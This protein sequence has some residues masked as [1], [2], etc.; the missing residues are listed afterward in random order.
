MSFFTWTKSPPNVVKFDDSKKLKGTSNYQEWAQDVGMSFGIFLDRLV[1]EGG[2]TKPADLDEAKAENWEMWQAWGAAQINATISLQGESP[3]PRDARKPK[4]IWDALKKAFSPTSASSLIVESLKVLSLEIPPHLTTEEFDKIMRT[5]TSDTERAVTVGMTLETLK[6]SIFIN[7]LPSSFSH[8]LAVMTNNNSKLPSLS[9][10]QS[11]VRGILQVAE[12]P[13]G[14]KESALNA[15][16]VSARKAGKNKGKPPQPCACGA[17]HWYD[18]CTDPRGIKARKERDSKRAKQKKSKKE[19]AEP[20]E[21]EEEGHGAYDEEEVYIKFDTTSPSS[22]IIADTGASVHISPPSPLITSIKTIKPVRIRGLSGVSIAHKQGELAFRSKEGHDFVLKRVLILPSAAHA[23]VSTS[24]LEDDFNLTFKIAK[25]NMS[26]IDSDGTIVASASR[27]PT[28]RLFHLNITR[29]GEAAFSGESVA[30]ASSSRTDPLTAHR[31]MCHLSLSSTLKVANRLA[32]ANDV[33]AVN[34]PCDTYLSEVKNCEPC[35]LAK[36][37]QAPHPPSHRRATSRLELVHSDLLEMPVRS[38]GG[39]KYVI[40]FL[41]DYSRYLWIALLSRK[42]EAWSAFE[43][44][45]TKIERQTGAK[46]KTL[47]SDQGGE[48]LS[49]QLQDKLK[50]LGI[51]WDPSTAYTPQENSRA[52][53]VNE[54]ITTRTRAILFDSGLDSTLR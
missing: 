11:G 21:A 38:H 54:T 35:L 2:D 14:G 16:T 20:A 15:S 30:I 27:T 34:T 49:H 3:V 32:P 47:R 37:K 28:S 53:A 5:W 40:T 7:A 45:R 6:S 9:E 24:K 26:M 51:E 4:V 19:S 12:G 48:Y 25:G 31:R 8:A 44:W 29:S 10:L 43:E 36:A 22:S 33:N 46:V 41:D 13:S 23:L 52:E 1:G 42:S 39:A 18:D 17:M 50:A